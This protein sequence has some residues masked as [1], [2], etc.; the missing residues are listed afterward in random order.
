MLFDAW[1]IVKLKQMMALFKTLV[2][3]EKA[4]WYDLA[5]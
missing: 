5:A 3:G 4:I 2:K 1:L